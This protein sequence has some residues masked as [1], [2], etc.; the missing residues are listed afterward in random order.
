M[1]NIIWQFV[2]WVSSLV[3]GIGVVWKFLEKNSKK[4][5]KAIAI[6]DE[7]LDV[8]RAIREASRDKHISSE[9]LK[10]IIGHIEELREVLK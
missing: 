4:I 9:E 10:I 3:L 6:A 1:E 5:D 7:S 2:A 8:V